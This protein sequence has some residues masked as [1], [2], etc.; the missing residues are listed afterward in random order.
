MKIFDNGFSLVELLIVVAIILI[1]VAIAI[2]DLM[3]SR[4]AANQ[5]SA[6]GSLR[7]IIT[8]EASYSA[9]YTAGF[10]LTLAELDGNADPATSLAAG[11]IDNVLGS[12]VKSGYTFY[13]VP[14]VTPGAP[15]SGSLAPGDCNGPIDTYQVS[16]NPNG[17]AGYGNFYYVDNSG[18]IRQNSKSPAGPSDPPIAG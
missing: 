13:Y 16:A 12:G 7:L 10:T 3:R 14:C 2:P 18:V 5:S 6:V 4:S 15:N 1:V 9:T 11:L 8:S 17:G